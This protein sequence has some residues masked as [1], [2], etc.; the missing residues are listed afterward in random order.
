M[1]ESTEIES[2]DK[3]RKVQSKTNSLSNSFNF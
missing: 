2:N 1:Y 3:T